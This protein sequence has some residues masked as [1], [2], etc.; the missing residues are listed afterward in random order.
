MK[1]V[2]VVLL[3]VAVPLA[4]LAAFAARTSS[5]SPPRRITGVHVVGNRLVDQAGQSVR[6]LGVDR[7]GTEYMCLS[8]GIFY[9]PSGADSVR[10][11]G[12]WHI[13]AVRIPLNEDCWLELNGVSALYSGANYRRAIERYVRLLNAAG[14]VAI[15]DLDWSAPGRI[16]AT[17]G[18][19]MA[20]QSHSP[21]FWHSVALAFKKQPGVVYD[22]YNEPRHLSW[23]CWLSGCRLAAGWTTAGMQELVDAVRRTGA[24]QPIMAGG[25]DFASDLSGWLTHEPHDP[26]HQL[27]ASVHIY[28]PGGCDTS[29]CWNKVLL[30][31]ERKVP[32]VSGE[33][34]EYDCG[35]GFIDRYMNWADH[36]DIS[37]LGWAWDT[38]G[39]WECGTG[40]ALIKTWTGSPTAYGVG[41]RDHFRALARTLGGRFLSD[42]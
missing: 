2:A 26:S 19:V 21:S 4:A 34:G 20:D 41:L 10:A 16:R 29:S 33:I 1:R 22:L 23:S 15:L 37:Y 24:R 32:V 11:M 8:S 18:E 17:G 5:T 3:A 27:I 12:S 28:R 35:K 13:D 40:P 25:I 39:G 36:H 31:L 38:G 7:S 30:P 42:G 9:G 14:M 6:L